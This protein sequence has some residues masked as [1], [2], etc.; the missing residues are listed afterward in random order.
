ME[1]RALWVRRPARPKKRRRMVL[2]VAIGSPPAFVVR[3]AQV[4]D[5]GGAFGQAVMRVQAEAFEPADRIVGHD[6]MP[7]ISPHLRLSTMQ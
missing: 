1:R 4:V 2:A 7:R 6:P 3:A 5:I